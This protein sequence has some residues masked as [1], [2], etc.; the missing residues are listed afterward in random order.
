MSRVAGGMQHFETF[1]SVSGMVDK[2]RPARP[3]AAKLT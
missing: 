1:D 2:D 3:Q